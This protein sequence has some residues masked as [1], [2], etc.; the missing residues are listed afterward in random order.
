M[1]PSVVLV[2]Y[3]KLIKK[4]WK[5]GYQATPSFHEFIPYLPH[6]TSQSVMQVADLNTLTALLS[7]N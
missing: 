4:M 2:M 5:P 3:I 7:P 1:S 6:K